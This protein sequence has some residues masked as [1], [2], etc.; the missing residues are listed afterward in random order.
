[1]VISVIGIFILSR[2]FT[3]SIKS[4]PTC[5]LATFDNRPDT[6]VLETLSK[7]NLP[8]VRSEIVAPGQL[9]LSF[10]VRIAKGA[11][12]AI[13]VAIVSHTKDCN[14]GPAPADRPV[15]RPFPKQFERADGVDHGMISALS[16]F[17]IEVNIHACS[18]V[19]VELA[20]FAAEVVAVSASGVL[21]PGPLFVANMLYGAK[22]GAMSGVRVAHGH[23]L[24]EI[25]VIAGSRWPL[26]RV[27]V[28][29]G[30]CKGYSLV[31]ASPYWALPGMQV[32]AVARKKRA[33]FY[34]G[35][36]GSVCD[37][38]CADC[39]QPVFPTVVAHS[40]NKVGLRLARIR[41]RGRSCAAFCPA[42]V[43]GLCV[44]DRQHVP[45]FKGWLC[46]A[47]K[48]LQALMYGLVP[49]LAYYGVQFL[50]SAL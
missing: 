13:K 29:I 9:D 19:A 5:W 24:V 36:K 37:R 39:A 38:R 45:R 12:R 1:M 34:R 42:R 21:A 26:F 40:R 47:E 22:Q 14:D 50:A 10:L 35:Q 25:A 49:L 30:K 15:C 48:V 4:G 32:F 31:A 27:G 46:I 6:I 23:A 20:E 43:D 33:D 2:Y 18:R 17:C 28:C 3:S 41:R 16:Y 8:L 7:T 11:H 44:A